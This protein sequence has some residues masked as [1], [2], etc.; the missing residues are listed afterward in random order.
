MSDESTILV[1][2]RCVGR[3]FGNVPAVYCPLPN[4][5]NLGY[6]SFPINN[7]VY[8][9]K[10]RPFSLAWVSEP[11]KSNIRVVAR[12]R[13]RVYAA[14]DD[15]VEVLNFNGTHLTRLLHKKLDHK[16]N[17][18]IPIGD[19]LVCIEENGF[20]N[21]V[22]VA[23]GSVLVEIETPSNF[24]ISSAFHPETYYNKVRFICESCL[25]HFIDCFGIN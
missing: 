24:T 22:D 6:I 18:L 16:I 23:D 4:S 7:S 5:V 17:F 8:T 25:I 11:L 13:K 20:I 1:P 15:G 21:V 9:Y 19:I 2:H 10:I 14:D 3:I 12:D